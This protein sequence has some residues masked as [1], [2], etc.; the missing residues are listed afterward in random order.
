RV[1]QLRPVAQQQLLELVDVRAAD[2]PADETRAGVAEGLD[3]AEVSGTIDDDR[4]AWI[5]QASRE[6]VEP[7]LRAGQDE[8]VLGLAAESVGERRAKPRHPLGR[9]VAP[10]GRRLLR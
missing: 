10:G 1:N 5:D 6:Q 4:V 2:V 7:L 3:R 9:S 8:D